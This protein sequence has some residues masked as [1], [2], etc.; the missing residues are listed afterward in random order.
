MINRSYV[1]G[2]ENHPHY[3]GNKDIS[4][5]NRRF[6]SSVPNQEINKI[7]KVLSDSARLSIY[8]LLHK[9]NEVSVTDI[10]HILD[11]GQ[12]TV[13]HALSDMKEAGLVECER[14]GKLMCYSL[15]KHTSP[16]SG[17]ISAINKYFYKL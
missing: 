1:S 11:L 13:S 6:K 9:V 17:V 16:Y 15:K 5:L 14:C 7:F 3:I 8:I 4:L 2:H 12:S 10:C